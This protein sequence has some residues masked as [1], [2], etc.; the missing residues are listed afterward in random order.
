MTPPDVQRAD[1]AS[2]LWLA[3]RLDRVRDDVESV[4]NRSRIDLGAA[5]RE[6]WP[7]GDAPITLADVPQVRQIVNL[8]MDALGRELATLTR[9]ARREIQARAVEDVARVFVSATSGDMDQAVALLRS[10]IPDVEPDA[11]RH[12]IDLGGVLGRH[13]LASAVQRETRAVMVRRLMGQVAAKVPRISAALDIDASLAY[14]ATAQTSMETA[15]SAPQPAARVVFMKQDVEVRDAKNH[16]IS[17]V[18]NGQTVKIQAPFVAKIADVEREAASLGRS[19]G[20]GA[21]LWSRKSDSWVGM[22]L[23][24][25]FNERGRVR[26][27]A[28]NWLEG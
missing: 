23:P 18:L 28:M 21:V 26:M 9:E 27:V 13:A 22:T 3:A 6:R 17:R 12:A 16:P 25:H 20:A 5:L 4:T 10:A 8:R 19:T 14:H 11:A 2:D 7:D 24:A 1:A 15:A